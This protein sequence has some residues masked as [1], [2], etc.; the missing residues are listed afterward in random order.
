M[1]L[2]PLVWAQCVS[3]E[4]LKVGENADNWCASETNRHCITAS[5]VILYPDIFLM[6]DF[7]H[8]CYFSKLYLWET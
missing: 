6:S 2:W 8:F 3:C 5:N 4:S 7:D 1:L